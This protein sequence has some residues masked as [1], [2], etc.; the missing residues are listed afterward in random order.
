MRA[1]N[2]SGGPAALPESVLEAAKAEFLDFGGLG[3]SVM[4]I[5]HR[6][7]AFEAIVVDARDTLR[8][9]MGLGDSHEILFIQGG[10]TQQFAQIPLGVLRAGERGGYVVTGAWGK[11]AVRDG[12]RAAKLVGADTSTLWTPPAS[13]DSTPFV[14]GPDWSAIEVPR[15]L[16]YAHITTNETVDGVM[17]EPPRTFVAPLVADMS[18]DFLGRPMRFDDFAV[19]YA[20]AQKN[21]GPSGLAVVVMRRDWLDRSD[22]ALPAP[23]SYKAIADAKSMLNTPPTFTLYL[24]RGVVRWLEAQG[25]IEAASE[26]NRAKAKAVYDAI[27]ESGGFYRCPVSPEVRSIMNVVFRLPTEDLDRAFVKAAEA[28]RMLGLK[29]HRQVGGIRA[30]LYN[31]VTLEWA[32]ALAAFMREFARTHG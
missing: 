28:E 30:S 4:E 5:S 10:A 3:A 1:M 13:A 2:F 23:W 27:D 31:A 15:G 25:G 29:G 14:V 19:A 20:G 17:I 8:R 7:Q 12:G 16:A 18:S 26:R 11:K 22:V 9:L 24:V 32:E 21:L 6:S